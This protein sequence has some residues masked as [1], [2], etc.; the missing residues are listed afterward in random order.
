MDSMWTYLART[1]A[2]DSLPSPTI[3]VAVR[4]VAD[5]RQE[6]GNRFRRNAKLPDD[7]S[8]IERNAGPP[9]QLNDAR[10]E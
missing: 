1:T 9:I 2:D 5:Q 6:I 7:A 10:A 8:L 3:K 4:R